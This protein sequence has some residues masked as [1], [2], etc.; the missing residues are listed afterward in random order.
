MDGKV[1]S[2][3]GWNQSSGG[4]FGDFL[5]DNNVQSAFSDTGIVPIYNPFS[6]E[7]AMLESIGYNGIVP[8]PAALAMLLTG[9]AGMRAVRLRLKVQ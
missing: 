8:E 7:F 5:S 6:P 3:I 4:D 2:I 9:L 1:T